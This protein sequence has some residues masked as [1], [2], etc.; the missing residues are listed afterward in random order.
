MGFT[1]FPKTVKFFEYFSRQQ[2]LAEEAADL[3]VALLKEEGRIS[4]QCRRI[5][6]LALETS[7][8]AREIAR[9]LAETFITPIDREDVYRIAKGYAEILNQ[10]RGLA[11]RVGLYQANNHR[12]QLYELF[13]DF[14]RMISGCGRLLEGIARESYDAGPIADILRIK[15]ESDNLLLVAMGE[16]HELGEVRGDCLTRAQV[17]DRCETLLTATEQFAFVLEAI[18]IKNA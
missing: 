12:N 14:Q 8:L 9:L 16:L 17:L 10:I 5:Y 15:T 4:D 6:E 2:R 3:L 1:L 18:G 7:G 11:V 13:V